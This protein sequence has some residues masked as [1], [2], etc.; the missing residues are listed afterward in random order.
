MIDIVAVWGLYL[1]AAIAAA[2]WLTLPVPGKLRLA[3]AAV[4]AAVLVAVSV[5]AAGMV[6]ADPRPFMVNPSIN[7]TITHATDN[8]FVSDHATAAAMLAAL[9][10]PWRR[11]VGL[12]M[13]LGAV[14]IGWARVTDGVHHWPDVL[15]G[16]FIG[17]VCAAVG[18]VVANFGEAKFAPQVHGGQ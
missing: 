3:A 14:A 4:V 15:G 16:L 17:L 5:K 7:P 18:A 10:V 11:W 8:G 6:W 2:V 13:L 1:L 12:A 9:I